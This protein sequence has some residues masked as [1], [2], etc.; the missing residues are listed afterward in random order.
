MNEFSVAREFN[1]SC[2]EPIVLEAE[3][4]WPKQ[5]H[6]FEKESVYA[7]K[8][9]LATCRPLLVRGEPGT[10][11]S[12][13][14]R[15]AAV[16]LKRPLLYEV[17]TA[18][19]EA[20]DL[21]Y[22]FDM[23]ARLGEAQVQATTA[24]NNESVV[25]ENLKPQKFISPGKIWWA[26]N[27]Q[28]ARNQSEFCT[29]AAPETPKNWKKE[30]GCVL[31][32]DEI[33]KADSDLP[34]AL[35]ECFSNRS[36]Q[37]PYLSKPIVHDAR[38]AA[39]LVIITTNEERELPAAFL[40]RCLVLHLKFPGKVDELQKYL[41]DRAEAHFAKYRKE[42]DA[43]DDVVNEAIKSLIDDREKA[44]ADATGV[45]KPGLAEFLDLLDTVFKI[46][47]YD[48]KPIKDVVN[49]FARYTLQKNPENED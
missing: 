14:A 27:W 40:R 39:P 20:T 37:V 49:R 44:K 12:Q 32:I 47:D 11:K 5:Y 26:L 2:E 25:R 17:I 33:D 43:F 24:K 16:V 19:T 1:P 4:G 6:L 34:N 30:Y 42:T 36:F 46:A 15:A 48:E 13:L 8:A 38:Q 18:R 7:V 9:A 10:G 28:E 45:A 21:L 22:C 41:K 35:L 29:I 31:L 23:V 3:G